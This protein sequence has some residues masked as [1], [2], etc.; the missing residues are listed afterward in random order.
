MIRWWRLKVRVLTVV[1]L[2]LAASFGSGPAAVTQTNCEPAAPAAVSSPGAATAV[3]NLATPVPFPAGGGS[4]TVFAA[5]SL[6]DVFGEIAGSLE[7]ANPGLTIT[8]ETAGSQALVTQLQEGAKAD[9]LATAN[10]S[11]MDTAVESGLIGG[12][13]Q[14]LTSNRLVIVTPSD[15]PAGIA[16]LDDLTQQGVK[17]VIAN[18][19]VPAGSYARKAFCAYET[20]GHEGFSDQVLANVVSE[21][22]DVRAVLTKVL[23]GEADAGVVYASDATASDLAG[24][25]LTVIEFPAGVPVTASYPIAAVSGGNSELAT[26]FISAVLGADGQAALATYGFGA[27]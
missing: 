19:D 16:S 18:Q 4:L 7:A 11:T 22:E 25:P 23:L 21:E 13:P 8:V 6:T 17:L 9:V 20:A 15:N 24:D 2:G 27:P 14:T 5:A 10:T 26:A 12:E 1:L 3:A